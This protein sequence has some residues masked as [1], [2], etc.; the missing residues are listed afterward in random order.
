MAAESRVAPGTSQQDGGP[1]QSSSKESR[2]Q[3]KGSREIV[4]FCENGFSSTDTTPIQG[5]RSW[6]PFGEGKDAH[7][8]F[9]QVRICY[10]AHNCN[11]QI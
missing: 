2:S 6:Q 1:L 7:K 5:G 10:F 11:L 3:A 4:L 9:G 8:N